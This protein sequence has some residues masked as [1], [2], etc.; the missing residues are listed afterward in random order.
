MRPFPVR[1]P[2]TTEVVRNKPKFYGPPMGHPP[3]VYN[4]KQPGFYTT[5]GINFTA[6][7]RTPEQ[8]TI[9]FVPVR[10]RFETAKIGMNRSSLPPG[11]PL[12]ANHHQT[13]GVPLR[14]AVTY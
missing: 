7:H 9:P 12:I 8:N 14:G 4:T 13:K 2:T 3:G 6:C 1:T 10:D 5:P 11:V